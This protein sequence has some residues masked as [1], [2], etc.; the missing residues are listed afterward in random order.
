MTW[1][2]LLAM[3]KPI[4]G[5]PQGRADTTE[6]EPKPPMQEN[7]SLQGY[8]VAAQER[9]S[10]ARS[11]GMDRGPQT[12]QR[13]LWTLTGRM[14]KLTDRRLHRLGASDAGIYVGQSQDIVV[15]NCRAERNVA[16]IEIENSLRRRLREQ[17]NEQHRR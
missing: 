7:L 2:N 15:R 17:S 8:V 1:K 16:G 10:S 5:I 11:H 9:A 6:Q 4:L 12:H 14:Q 3:C 13:G